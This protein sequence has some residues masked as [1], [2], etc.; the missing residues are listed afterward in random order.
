MG[1]LADP[2]F[3]IQQQNRI[4]NNQCPFLE[5]HLKTIAQFGGPA[6]RHTEDQDDGDEQ[7][8]DDRGHDTARRPSD[9]DQQRIPDDGETR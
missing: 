8:H 4:H 1:R 3:L 2:A 5:F 6:H 9:E 7:R